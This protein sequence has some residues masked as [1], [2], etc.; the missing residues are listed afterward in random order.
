MRKKAIAGQ[1][2][3]ELAK[4]Y[5]DDESKSQGGE[6]GYFAPDEIMDKI[7]EAAKN[8][9]PGQI[10]EVVQSSHGFHVL[11]LEAH[12]V[13]GPK[14]LALV[15]E[16]IRSKLIDQTARQRLEHWVETDLVKQHYVETMY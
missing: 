3:G 2:F 10:S 16:E 8:L 12:D 1:D 6:L 7:L 13:P 11:K 9:K 4:Q 15:K 14:P 5:S